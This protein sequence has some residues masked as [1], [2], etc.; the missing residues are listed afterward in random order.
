MP[1]VSFRKKFP[2]ITVH[3]GA[4]LMNSLLDAGLPVASSCHGDGVCGKCGIEIVAGMENLSPPNA[5]ESILRERLKIPKGTRISC[6][7]RIDGDVEVDT[8]YW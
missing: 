2:S 5:V 3:P 4:Q 8:P 1:T 7:T 6:Q